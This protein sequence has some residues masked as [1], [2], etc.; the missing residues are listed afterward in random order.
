MA[1]A[2]TRRGVRTDEV[3]GDY[4][5]QTIAVTGGRGYVGSA[6]IEA[7]RHT[8]ARVLLVTRGSPETPSGVEVLTADVR[9]QGCWRDIVQRAD[10]IFHLAGNTSVYAAAR[11]PADSLGTTALPLTHL[12][13][14]AQ[15]APRVVYASTATVYGLT[16]TLPVSEQTEPSPTTAYDMHKLFGERLLKLASTQGVLQGV[17][18]RLGAVYGPSAGAS[19]AAERGVLNRMTRV[20]LQGCDLPLYGD[21][22]YLREFVYIDDVVRAFLL[23]GAAPG[24]VGDT[25]NVASGRGITV[26]DAFHLVAT[27]VEQATGREISVRE[28][29][30]PHEASPIEFRHFEAD[31]SRI[32]AAC[33]W[34]PTVSLSDGIDRLITADRTVRG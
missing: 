15:R 2:P 17:S 16:D 28:V 11:D 27:R 6:L 34:T 3:A 30:W 13:A 26:R 23:T 33:G 9:T 12:V 22:N 29:P 21:G 7:L 18:L 8:P 19:S 25:F 5:G 1:P 32:S 31:I 24:V 4:E 14:A 20:A 10:V